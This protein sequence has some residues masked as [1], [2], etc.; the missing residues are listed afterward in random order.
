[1]PTGPKG[2]KRSTDVISAAV[3][4]RRIANGQEEETEVASAS[5]R[6]REGRVKAAKARTAKLTERQR[7][8]IAHVAAAAAPDP[9]PHGPYKKAG[10]SQSGG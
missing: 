8:E 4:V 10:V 9:T 5:E 3:K 7:A 1:M 6:A 2:Q